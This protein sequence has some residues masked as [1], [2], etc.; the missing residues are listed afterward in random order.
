MLFQLLTKFPSFRPLQVDE[1]EVVRKSRKERRLARSGDNDGG[2]DD[3][4]DEITFN[5]DRLESPAVGQ[6]TQPTFFCDMRRKLSIISVQSRFSQVCPD[7]H[8]LPNA[9]VQKV[10]LEFL[11]T[12][13]ICVTDEKI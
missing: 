9:N 11:V 4:D 10:C 13:Q 2:D 8:F 1:K 7:F 6:F 12:V 3:G 5:T